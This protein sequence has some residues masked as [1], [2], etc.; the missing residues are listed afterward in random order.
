M[1]H[2][3]LEKLISIC[4]HPL[5]YFQRSEHECLDAARRDLAAMRTPITAKALMAVGW[6]ERSQFNF[7]MFGSGISVL[8]P[9]NVAGAVDVRVRSKAAGGVTNMYDL[10]ELVRLLGGGK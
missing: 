8:F 9:Y 2:D 3:E 6:V 10:T 5:A 4:D 1:T 7:V